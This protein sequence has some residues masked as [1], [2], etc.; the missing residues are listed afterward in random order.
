MQLSADGTQVRSRSLQPHQH[1]TIILRDSIKSDTPVEE[2]AALFTVDLK[3][4][5][6]KP[7]LN[8]IWYVTFA[9]DSIA[10]QV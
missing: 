6:I 9:T 7:D 8:N 5:E 1:A 4:I 2:V 10:H 3:P